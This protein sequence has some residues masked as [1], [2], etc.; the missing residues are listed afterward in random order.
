MRKRE[1]N[2]DSTIKV[3]NS[4]LEWAGPVFMLIR[5][6]QPCNKSL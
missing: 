6:P 3:F 1:R 2:T 5:M 4:L